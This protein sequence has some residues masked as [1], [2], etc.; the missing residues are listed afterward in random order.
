MNKIPFID[1]ITPHLELKEEFLA[2]FNEALSTG[3]FIGGPM[4]ENFEK[5][6]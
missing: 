2:V 4:V 6:S 5:D 1:L 3:G